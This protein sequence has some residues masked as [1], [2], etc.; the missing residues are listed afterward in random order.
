MGLAVVARDTAPATRRSVDV[1]EVVA[2]LRR[3]HPRA[4]EDRLVEMLVE[5]LE[6]DRHLLVDAGRCLVQKM[7]AAFETRV[8]QSR[9]APSPVE[10][11]ERQAAEKSAVTAL[12]AKV[13]GSVLDMMIGEKA[14]R[15]MTGAEVGRLGLGF[16]RL[17]SRIPP[18]ARVGDCVSESQAAALIDLK[19]G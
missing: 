5:R 1:R 12:A 18:G 8:R 10:R 17:A 15:D 7:L 11:A 16:Q 6:E 14:L 3:L 19:A 13:R 4:G 2:E 9:A